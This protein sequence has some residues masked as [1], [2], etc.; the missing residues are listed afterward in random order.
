MSQFSLI[1]QISNMLTYD[2]QFYMFPHLKLK[3]KKNNFTTVTGMYML[4]PVGT[5]L[6]SFS[7]G[8]CKLLRAG[9]T[10]VMYV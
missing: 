8:T 1:P 3:K 10:S 9:R 7:M 2:K 4:Y 6:E 5:K